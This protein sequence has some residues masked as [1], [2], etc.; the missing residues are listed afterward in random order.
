MAFIGHR[1]CAHTD[2]S[3]LMTTSGWYVATRWPES[4]PR[5]QTPRYPSYGRARGQNK[6]PG[7]LLPLPLDAIVRVGGCM[8]WTNC[9]AKPEGQQRAP[10]VS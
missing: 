6:K 4:G 3:E 9:Q 8:P 7:P 2:N 10:S 5:E 1:K